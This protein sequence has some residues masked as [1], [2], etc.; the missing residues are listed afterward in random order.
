MAD[1]TYKI[2]GLRKLQDA[3]KKAP[4]VIFNLE[5]QAMHRSVDLL[6]GLAV[7]SSPR[8]P[9]HFGFHMIDRW[10]THVSTGPRRIVGVVQ[11]SAVQA[12]LTEF[13]TRPHLIKSTGHG[14]LKMGEQ[15]WSTVIQHP[16]HKGTHMTKKALSAS[17]GAIR[18]FFLTAA[19]GV[20]QSMATSGD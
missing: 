7:M 20:T 12:R 9:G 19:K 10:S 18:V 15:G 16:G 5:M 3:T 17:R 14:H 11:N 1:I 13:D 6:E 2:A 4:A 8:G